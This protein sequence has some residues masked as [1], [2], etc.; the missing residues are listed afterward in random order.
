[1]ATDPNLARLDAALEVLGPLAADLCLVGGCA[2]SL[3]I[4]DPGASPLR[5]TEDVDV[6]L[7]ALYYH[8]YSKF[9]EK[10]I[11]IGFTQSVQGGDPICRWRL[12]TVVLDV[13]PLDESVLGFGSHWY[14]EAFQNRR[15]FDTQAGVKIA[16]V[17][18]PHFLATKLNAFEGRGG[19]DFVMSH[20]LEDIIRVI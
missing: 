17:D 3:L 15:M 16:C 7:E 12:K 18:G 11:R 13:M 8:E 6:I 10:L 14:R 5:L 20:D 1:M 19:G 2:A 9:C 4:S